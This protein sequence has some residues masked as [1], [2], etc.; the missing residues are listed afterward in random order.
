M[1]TYSLL[2]MLFLVYVGVRGVSV[3]VLLWPAVAVHAMPV[4]LLL[5]ARFN[6]GAGAAGDQGE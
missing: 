4:A 2:A 1:L 5:R 6:E 3:G